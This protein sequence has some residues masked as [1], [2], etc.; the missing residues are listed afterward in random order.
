MRRILRRPVAVG[1][2]LRGAGLVAVDRDEGELHELCQGPLGE[3]AALRSDEQPLSGCLDDGYFVDVH[4]PESRMPRTRPRVRKNLRLNQA[5]LDR[6]RRILGTATETETVEQALD[7]VAFR[8]EVSA[9]VRRLAGS[10]TLRDP[11]GRG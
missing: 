7:L 11:F 1:R 9:G 6:A 3:A 4:S 8:Q 2:G 5:K 10:K